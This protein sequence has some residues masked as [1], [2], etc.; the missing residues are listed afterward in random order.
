MDEEKNKLMINMPKANYITVLSVLAAI[1]VVILHTKPN[2]DTFRR[3]DYWFMA[4]VVECVFHFAVPIFF[5]ISGATLIDY[6]ERYS[7]KEF[8]KKRIKKT[9]IPFIIWSIIGILYADFYKNNLEICELNRTQFLNAIFGIKTIFVYWFFP[10]LFSAYLCIPLFAA[11]EK[12]RRKEV[13]GYLLIVGAIFNYILP[14]LNNV[15]EK[16]LI[17]PITVPV[18]SEYLFYV[19]LGYLLH[20]TQIDKKTE[21]II[22]TLG[23]IGLLLQIFGTYILSEQASRLIGVFKGITN[24]PCAL[25]SASIFL[26]VK[27]ICSQIKNVSFLSIINK[28]KKYTFSIYLIHWYLI[29]IIT[30]I[31]DF[32]TK[33]MIYAFGMPV[34]VIPLCVLITYILRKIPIIRH[35]VPE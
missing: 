14:F 7:T 10:P 5:M 2:V 34:I 3:E 16:N 18:L 24:V 1:A 27:N 32:N 23:M 26:L 33:S 17:L 9:F 29:E 22:Y 13:F 11:V 28:M 20:T 25:Y 12:K 31:C 6:R 8:F 21:C 35:I 4:N 30:D 15:F 19:I